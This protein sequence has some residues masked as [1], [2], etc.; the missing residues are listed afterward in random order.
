MTVALD[1]VCYWYPIREAPALTDVS[2]CVPAGESWLLAGPSGSGKST[3]LRL[4]NGLV[5]QF[6]GG[7]IS[8]RVSV[9]GFDPA[10]TPTRDL[11]AIAGMVFQ[12]PEAQAIADT[13]RNEVAFGMEQHGI[14]RAEMQSRL[15]AA[16]EATGTEHLAARR[17]ATLSGGERQRVAIASALAL[18][19]RVLLLD[20]PTSQIDP[21]GAAHI[22]ELVDVARRGRGMT[23]LIAEHRLDRVLPMVDQVAAFEAGHVSVSTPAKAA[24]EL[25]VVPS[26]V[27]LGRRLGLDPLPLTVGAAVIALRGRRVEIVA[28]RR[29]PASGALAVSCRG[30]SFSFGSVEAL[31]SVDFELREG[32]VVALAGKN[33]SGKTTLLRTIAGTLR[34]NAGTVEFGGKPASPD[35]RERT[36]VCGLVPQDPALALY[37]RTVAEEIE[38]T[39]RFRGRAREAGLLERWQLADLAARDPRDISVGQQQRVAVAAMLAHEPQVWLLDEPTRGADA[40]YRSW[41]A[42]RLTAH[43]AAGGSVAVATHDVEF[44]AQV[45]TRVVGLRGGRVEFDLPARDALGHGGPLPTQVAQVVPGALLPEDVAA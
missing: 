3:F 39:R 13:V 12:E 37:Q 11:A 8:G 38:E 36:N 30:L 43:A 7:R 6:H 16:L 44:A 27:A 14:P 35:V 33:G 45:A 41:L 4:V 22:L 40:A 20:E 32:E 23:L 21:E 19:P 24:A 28:R 1:R 34:P 5:P 42:A 31:R 15:K 25:A 18:H 17:L 2:L 10:R 29:P 9:A 26:L